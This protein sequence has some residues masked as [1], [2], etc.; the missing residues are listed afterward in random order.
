MSRFMRTARGDGHDGGAELGERETS[1]GVSREWHAEAGK[2]LNLELSPRERVWSEEAG[3][4]DEGAKDE[5]AR[6]GGVRQRVEKLSDS[7]EA[8][9]GKADEESEWESHPPAARA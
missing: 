3:Q 2:D 6:P 8:V 7:D 1:R 9:G 4:A 5:A